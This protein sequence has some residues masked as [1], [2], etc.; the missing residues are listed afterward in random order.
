M[1]NCNKKNKATLNLMAITSLKKSWDT[2]KKRL[3]K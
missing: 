3:Q 2:G 1:Y